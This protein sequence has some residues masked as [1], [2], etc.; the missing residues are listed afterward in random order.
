[1][2]LKSIEMQVALPR[3][4]DSS[5]LHEQLSQRG[6]HMNDQAVEEM[7]QEEWKLRSSVLK[8]EQKDEVKLQQDNENSKDQR[9]H[10]EKNS[11]KKQNNERQTAKNHP[12]KGNH[13]DFSG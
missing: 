11:K 3:T 4:F 13:I 9:D 8:Q 1:M 5:K 2:S 7:K 6:Q 12:Y 10:K